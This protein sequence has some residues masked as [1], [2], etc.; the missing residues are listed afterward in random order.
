MLSRLDLRA[1]NGDTA[2]LASLLA[3]PGGD[4]EPVAAVREIIAAVRERGDAALRELTARF[5][6]CAID[7][8]RVSGGEMDAALDGVS[9]EFGA[10][11]RYARAEITAYHEAQR[12]PEVRVERDGVTLRELVVPVDRAGLYVPG[13]RA[14]YPS[15]VLMTAIPAQV[16][17]VREIALCVPPDRD[18]HIA[19]PTLAAAALVGITEVYRVGGAQAIAAMAYGTDTIRAVD[20]IV[21]PGNVYVALAKREVAG[22]VGIESMAGPSEL[23][24]VADD[25]ASA[26][27]VAADLLAQ[28]EHGPDGAA[29]LVTWSETVVDAVDRAIDTLLATA[30]RRDDIEATLGSGGRAI[31]VDGPDAAMRVANVI[32][33]EHLELM[34]VD[35]DALVL[36]VRN[37]GAVFCGPWA[38]AVVGDY[39]AGVNHVL[40]TARTARFA[41]ALRVDDFRKHV[42]VV[43]VDEAALHR[44]APHIAAFAAVEG[45]DA[46]A[47][48]VAMRTAPS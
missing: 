12:G 3:R 5:D 14:A 36:L 22:V 41:S 35:P 48:A 42:H 26:D 32:A 29:V 28:A 18:G 15:T 40:P 38:P 25:T 11:L 23:V 39:V 46:H 17:G 45:L 4:D 43:D 31:L 7:D 44:I 10:A 13:G 34:T 47:R 19:A 16:A 21:G 33:P 9:A 27:N 1:F 8:L 6:G 37:A 24:V 30:G 20:V 2:A